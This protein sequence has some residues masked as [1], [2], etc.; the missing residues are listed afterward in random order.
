VTSIPRPHRLDPQLAKPAYTF[1]HEHGL[2]FHCCFKPSIPFIAFK[3]I[4][5]ASIYK[6]INNTDLFVYLRLYQSHGLKDCIL[7]PTVA[8]VQVYQSV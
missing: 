4:I 7:L 6:Q 8:V 5:H 3:S 2:T 1:A